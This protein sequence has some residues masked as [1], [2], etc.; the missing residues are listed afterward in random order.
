M[1]GLNSQN[2]ILNLAPTKSQTKQNKGANLKDDDKQEFLSSLIQAIDE[3]N[4]ILPQK[5]NNEQKQELANEVFK[6]LQNGTLSQDDQ[7]SIFESA[8]FM[9]ILGLLDALKMDSK[10]INLNQFSQKTKQILSIEKN[11]NVLKNA[12][13]LN[14]L[15]DLAK[16]L[17]L[18]IEKI[19]V[20]RLVELKN[21]F[22]NLD[23]AGF[24]NNNIESVL[25]DFINQK[26]ANLIKEIPQKNQDSFAKKPQKENILSKALQ[27]IN[28]KQKAQDDK[29]ND[30]TLLNQ[31]D[32]I[33]SADKQ[34]HLENSKKNNLNNL[35]KESVQEQK[36]KIF[37]KNEAD[38]KIQQTTHKDIEKNIQNTKKNENEILT[39]NS[40]KFHKMQSVN[41]KEE[42]L[43]KN[44]TE[45]LNK[46]EIFKNSEDIQENIS[47]NKDNILKENI[48]ENPT[49]NLK[50]TNQE[51]P[52]NAKNIVKDLK[53]LETKTNSLNNT[54]NDTNANKTHTIN[55]KNPISPL[56][57]FFKSEQR[58][59]KNTQNQNINHTLNNTNSTIQNI[60]TKQNSNQTLDFTQQEK[61]TD[62]KNENNNTKDLQNDAFHN[63][64]NNTLKELSK[65]SQNQIKNPIKETFSHFSEDLKEQI[66]NYKAPITKVN[67]TLN[68]SNLGEVEVTL[69]Q[70]GNNLHINFNSNTN[71]MNLFIQHQAEFKNS[72]VN[73]GFTGLEMNFSDQ[74]KKEQNGQQK[75]KHSYK[76]DFEID[77]QDKELELVL[78][79]YF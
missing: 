76:N 28:L 59:N 7:I 40:D 19:K 12:K 21:T 67:I 29:E 15:L 1:S 79:K 60:Q 43:P 24:F 42:N 54:K 17:D 41:K 52:Q 53:D 34:N 38:L 68:P 30:A 4:E 27:D 74:G 22:P 13:D 71:T 32:K 35:P 16:K 45:I 72:L 10:A 26:I 70:R 58:E 62:L 5:L 47:K 69:M 50:N 11:L 63:E 31:K 14:E 64:L 9:Q 33:I 56:Q 8:N 20:D 49:K 77:K 44:T 61:N 36:N 57:E 25:K 65:V 6:Q 3:K 51:I 46:N 73:M 48:L 75:S 18:N 78:A 37:L 23:K 39:L 55:E 66:Q 2:D